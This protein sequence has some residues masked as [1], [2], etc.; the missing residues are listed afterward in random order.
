MSRARKPPANASPVEGSFD[1]ACRLAAATSPENEWHALGLQQT[2]VIGHHL[3]RVDDPRPGL[4][5]AEFIGRHQPA[6]HLATL[7][8]LAVFDLLH[9]DRSAGQERARSTWTELEDRHLDTQPL[10]PVVHLAAGLALTQ[11]GRPEWR[12]R[13]TSGLALFHANPDG[14]VRALVQLRLIAAEAALSGGDRPLAAALA[15]EVQPFLDR[16]PAAV[17]LG[18]WSTELADR[19]ADPRMPAGG[20]PLSPSERSVL[21]QLAT[22][23]TL[24]EVAEHLYISRN[25]VKSHTASIYRKLGVS[26]RS[27]G[28]ASP[29]PRV[30]PAAVPARD[31]PKGVI[32]GLC[33]S[34]HDAARPRCWAPRTPPFTPR[35]AWSLIRQHHPR[36]R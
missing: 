11:Q 20:T 4:M 7:A 10:L 15:T 17:N 24:P 6:V 25:T 19:V 21:E 13:I 30:P 35:P 36:I 32:S 34:P 33:R 1:A 9:G 16:M 23:L 26:S 27:T 2:A 22:H 31:H 3:G 18:A 5:E 12:D 28:R 8:Q 14:P 29:G